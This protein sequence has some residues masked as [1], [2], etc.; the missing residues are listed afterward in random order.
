MRTAKTD[1]TG[2]IRVFAGRTL[3]LLVLSCRGSFVNLAKLEIGQL[4]TQGTRRGHPCTLDTFLV[5]T[6]CGVCHIKISPELRSNLECP[7]SK[8]S[9]PK[10]KVF[11]TLKC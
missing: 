4:F 2:P 5:L 8:L 9:V 11:A 7:Y 6:F 1:Q 3:T 10:F